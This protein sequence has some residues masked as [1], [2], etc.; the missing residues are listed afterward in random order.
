MTTLETIREGES[1]FT[2]QTENT[3]FDVD[4][5]TDTSQLKE[6]LWSE[7]YWPDS[8]V[9]L[10]PK[11]VARHITSQTIAILEAQNVELEGNKI[12]KDKPSEGIN[13]HLSTWRQGYNQALQDT[14]NIN[15]EIIKELRI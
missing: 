14:I 15:S 7:A 13:K 12:Q 6:T 3:Y 4:N 8:Q 10:D 1:E 2:Q 9:E 11:K 5:I